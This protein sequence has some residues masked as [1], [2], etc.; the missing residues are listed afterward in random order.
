MPTEKEVFNAFVS[1][2]L[3]MDE[4]GV[5]SLYNEDGTELREGALTE[6]LTH[7]ANR[8]AALKPDTKKYFDD[9][10]KK[11]QSE[12][13]G[14]FE[15]DVLKKFNLKSDKKGIEL[16]DDLVAQFNSKTGTTEEEVKKSKYFLDFMEAAAK[17]RDELLKAKQDEFESFKKQV[18][19]EKHFKE[20]SDKAL[21]IFDNLKP[22]LPE[23]ASKAA[24]L[25]KVFI[26]ELSSYQYEVREGSVVVLD[27]D[28]N[29]ALDGHGH[30]V[31]FESLVQSTAE[32]Y[33]DFF[34]SDGKSAPAHKREGQKP[35]YK[36]NSEQD[37]IR[38]MAEAKTSEEKIALSDAYNVFKYGVNK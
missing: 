1:K 14:N 2:T 12:S 36:I 24:N 25:K 35:V 33:F 4:T 22:I 8:I 30:R 29:D 21:V 7:D 18:D 9:G 11:G 3:N 34:Q 23:D 37:F 16:I 19:R 6:L 13:L 5:A 27:S 17:E 10:Y 15:R 38:L 31:K 32:K 28:G 26:N 20:V